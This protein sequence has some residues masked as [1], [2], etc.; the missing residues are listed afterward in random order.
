MRTLVQ[1]ARSAFRV[2]TQP[3]PRARDD[4]RRRETERRIVSS[5]SSGDI[6]LQQGR[7]STR[8]DIGRDRARVLELKL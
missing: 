2:R 7:F 1:A 5:L 6:R 3:T 4:A 8:E